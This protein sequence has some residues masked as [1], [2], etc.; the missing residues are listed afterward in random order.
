MPGEGESL[1]PAI[2][3]AKHRPV[4]PPATSHRANA[5][6]KKPSFI[7]R[8]ARF[9]QSDPHPNVSPKVESFARQC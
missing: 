7:H 1:R 5:A 8:D 3:L 9:V 4:Q 2:F 6:A